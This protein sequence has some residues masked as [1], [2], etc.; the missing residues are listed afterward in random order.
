MLSIT[1]LE[2]KCKNKNIIMLFDIY[3]RIKRKSGK[4]E[5][6]WIKIK[7]KNESSIEMSDLHQV[8]EAG[9]VIYI[10]V[11]CRIISLYTSCCIFVYIYVHTCTFVCTHFL[12]SVHCTFRTYIYL[13]LGL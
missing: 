4:S 9:N 8:Y 12:E 13:L 11:A 10:W 6:F 1:A 5:R 2:I 3:I 7:K